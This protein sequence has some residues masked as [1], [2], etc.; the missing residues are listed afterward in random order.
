VTLEEALATARAHQPQLRQAHATSEA[1]AARAD[2]ARAPL[3]PQV[4]AS[5]QYQRLTS[6]FV[7]RPGALPTSVGRSGGTSFAT[8]NFFQ[9]SITAS[10]LLYD[11]GQ[12]SERWNAARASATSQRES[13]RAT[14]LQSTL[15]VRTAYFTARANQD[16]VGVARDN[17]ANQELH[18]RQTEAFVRIGTRPEI[19]LALARTAR[20]NAQVQLINAENAYSTAKAQLNQAMGVEESTGYAVGTETI[21]AVAGEDQGIDALRSSRRGRSKAAM[22]RRSASPPAS[23]RPAPRSTRRSATG[24][25]RRRSPGTCSRA[26]SRARSRARR[27]RTTTRRAR[28]STCCGSRCGWTSS[29]RASRCARGRRRCPP[30]ARRS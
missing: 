15:A 10:Q 22:D 23:P 12:T 19:D 7:A 4:T 11:F 27:A 21:P 6:N 28:R 9:A 13:E 5:A 30:P 25:P 16:L 1:A 2:E 14:A 18:L 8:D 26:G 29:R 3:L 24:T 17:L 20:A